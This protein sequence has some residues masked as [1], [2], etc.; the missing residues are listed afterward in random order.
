MGQSKFAMVN[1]NY[2]FSMKFNLLIQKIKIF[3]ALQRSYKTTIEFL[4]GYFQT[5]KI[6]S[7][8]PEPVFISFDVFTKQMSKKRLKESKICLNQEK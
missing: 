6:K 8:T 1:K 7:K 2:I 3:E 4:P 5:V